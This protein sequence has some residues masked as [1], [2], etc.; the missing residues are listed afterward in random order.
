[1]TAPH[2][3]VPRRGETAVLA[4]ALAMG[5]LICFKMLVTYD[6]LPGWGSDP[7]VSDG[8]V[9]VSVGPAGQLGV[10]VVIMALAAGVMAY[11]WLATGLLAWADGV[12][13]LLLAIGLGVIAYHLTRNRDGSIEDWL[14]GTDMAAAISA[15]SACACLGAIPRVRRAMTGLLLGVVVV[16]VAK[17]LLQYFV[18]QPQTV[19]TYRASREQILAANGWSPDSPMAMAYERRLM[20]REAT[21]WFGL[22]NVFASITGASAVALIGIAWDSSRSGARRLATAAAVMAL[23]GLVLSE[24]K[25]GIASAM[26]GMGVLLAFRWL[27]A[28]HQRISAGSGLVS[29]TSHPLP[30][31]LIPWLMVGLMLAGQ[32]GIAARGLL[33]D[34]LGELSLWFRW[35]YMQGAARI[36][37]QHPLMGAGPA[38]F[39]D[40]Y[41]LAKTPI[42]PEDVS[43]PHSL[44]WDLAATLGVG[45]L[46]L[47]LLWVSWVW[48]AGRNAARSMCEDELAK[49]HGPDRV[50]DGESQWL[51]L[52]L[53]ALTAA[54]AVI[55]SVWMERAATAPETALMKV[56]GL[57]GWVACATA[58]G[59]ALG[60]GAASRRS[61]APLAL[62]AAAAGL[63]LHGQIE[64]TPI[65]TGAGAW[66]MGIIGLAAAS[67][68]PKTDSSSEYGREIAAAAAR[69]A[70]GPMVHVAGAAGLMAVGACIVGA[71][72]M[73]PDLAAWQALLERS[74][75]RAL[76]IT[77]ARDEIGQVMRSGVSP[78]ER[79]AAITGILQS[80]GLLD[81]GAEPGKEPSL[82]RLLEDRSFEAWNL[83]LTDLLVASSIIPSHAPT[84]RAASQLALRLVEAA[85]GRSPEDHAKHVRT[86]LEEAQ[87]AAGCGRQRSTSLGWLAT[88]RVGLNERGTAE[89]EAESQGPGSLER[90]RAA[91]EQAVTLDPYNYHH[92]Q[93]LARLEQQLG[94]PREAAAW[95][96]KALEQEQLGKLDPLTMMDEASR[97][98]MARLAG[99]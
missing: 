11:R 77:R 62:G 15:G 59:R 69:P 84:H 4:A 91:L 31:R 41:L 56:A 42:A 83:S 10:N 79:S 17:G 7:T 28:R 97:R 6:V 57:L 96:R 67:R 51:E 43:S 12:R 40:A 47:L 58:I 70:P 8:V 65:W 29:A 82:D 61:A 94:R 71:G 53:V 35:F 93:S 98:E 44:P 27:R 26:I 33:G 90:A 81:G 73:Y 72:S 30:V 74:A 18:E 89:P 55:A 39:K 34:R 45:G 25:G 21:G 88:V 75:Q 48:M 9:G 13:S 19:E 54:S 80:S 99:N 76:V 78:A 95:A 46:A 14:G 86:S 52:R 24:S 22:S 49:A 23:V 1:M 64:M 5:G 63:G 60:S 37:A 87:A 20:Q 85:K 32:A 66:F 50:A 36:F 2:P 38:G 92:S 68:E 3:R 16:V